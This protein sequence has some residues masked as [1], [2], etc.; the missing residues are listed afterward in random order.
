M[1]GFASPSIYASFSR[2]ALNPQPLPPASL[3]SL[4][5]QPLPPRWIGYGW[6]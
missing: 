2:V 6:R 4:N 5:P 1:Y 3:V